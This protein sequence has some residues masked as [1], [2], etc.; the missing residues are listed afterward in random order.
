MSPISRG[1]EVAYYRQ[2]RHTSMSQK[3]KI[4]IRFGNRVRKIRNSQDIS[5]ERLAIDAGIERSYM[6][7]IERGERNPTL[8]KIVSIA[9]ALKVKTSELL[10]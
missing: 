8:V 4:L 1:L 10:D 5:Q 9:K 3:D 7:A 6:G 2:L